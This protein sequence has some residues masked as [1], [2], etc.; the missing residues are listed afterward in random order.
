MHGPRYHQVLANIH[1][2][3]EPRTYIEIGVEHGASLQLVGASTTAIGIDPNPVLQFSLPANVSIFAET[4]DAFFARPN[5]RELL[6]DTP[7]DLAFIDGMHHFEHALRDF[8]NLEKLCHCSSVI[9]IH[10]CFPLDRRTAQRERKTTFWSGDVWRLILILKRERPDLRLH[11]IATPP[12]GLCVVTNLNSQSQAL[13]SKLGQLT[14]EFMTLDFD[15]LRNDRAAKLNL[16]PNDWSAIQGLL[17]TAALVREE[18]GIAPSSDG[19][20]NSGS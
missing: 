20:R 13:E 12:T 19:T 4:S 16:F 14:Q 3:L 8:V 7:L 6:G 5:V 9:L 10:D 2:A 18:K 17:P 11:T 1:R 15:Y